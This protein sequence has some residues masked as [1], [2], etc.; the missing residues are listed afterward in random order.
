MVEA[1]TT[2]EHNPV[3]LLTITAVL[4]ASLKVIYSG[5]CIREDHILAVLTLI[6]GLSLGLTV[7][8]MV[9]NYRHNRYHVVG[10]VGT[11][12]TLVASYCTI[13]CDMLFLIMVANEMDVYPCKFL[14]PLKATNIIS[15]CLGTVLFA[16]TLSTITGRRI[17]TTSNRN[18]EVPPPYTQGQPNPTDPIDPIDP[19]LVCGSGAGP[20]PSP[21]P[22]PL[23][24]PITPPDTQPLLPHLP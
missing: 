4:I 8:L 24:S 16:S 7:A 12:G 14:V 9:G 6:S 22:P 3:N 5:L 13:V 18:S 17:S 1:M 10:M 21:S 2:E 11:V 20:S 15:L 23:F 19:V